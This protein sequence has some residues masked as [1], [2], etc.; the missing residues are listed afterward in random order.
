MSGPDESDMTWLRMIQTHARIAPRLMNQYVSNRPRN[1]TPLACGPCTR[2][3][4][5]ATCL[6][7]AS[8]SL[9]YAHRYRVTLR[10]WFYDFEIYLRYFLA[11]L[12]QVNDT[13]IFDPNNSV[14]IAHG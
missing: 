3:R 1:E 14:R 4:T 8:T 9:V 11:D 12:K 2:A 13:H 10:T 6:S 5:C 7:D